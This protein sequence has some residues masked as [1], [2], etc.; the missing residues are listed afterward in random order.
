MK[1]HIEHQWKTFAQTC[2]GG[3]DS[4]PKQQR[5]D[6]KRTFYGGIAAFIG[7]T[8][9]SD[10][11]QSEEDLLSEVQ[12]ELLTFNEDVKAGRA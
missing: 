11:K 5:I 4:L 9:E 10:P 7:L 2:F 6:I 8:M 1:K 3:E 12:A